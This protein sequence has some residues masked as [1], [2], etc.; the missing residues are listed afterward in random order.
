MDGVVV[1]AIPQT[2]IACVYSPDWS[3]GNWVELCI[4]SVKCGE[5][6]HIWIALSLLLDV[7]YSYI[8]IYI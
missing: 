6:L 1:F 7:R 2:P 5:K 4:S 3:A 8:H